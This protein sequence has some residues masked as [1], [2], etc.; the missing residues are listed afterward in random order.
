[1]TKEEGAQSWD[2]SL[3]VDCSKRDEGVD[4]VSVSPAKEYIGSPFILIMQATDEKDKY[5][6]TIVIH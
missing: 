3:G 4:E 5:I 1:M 6:A 2:S